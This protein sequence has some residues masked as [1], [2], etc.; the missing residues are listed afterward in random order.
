MPGCAGPVLQVRSMVINTPA[1]PCGVLPK[2]KPR[3]KIATLFC[4]R[5]PRTDSSSWHFVSYAPTSIM[6]KL[7]P[8]FPAHGSSQPPVEPVVVLSRLSPAAAVSSRFLESLDTNTAE[9]FVAVF[10]RS[11]PVVVSFPCSFSP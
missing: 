11:L 1:L 7:P 3:S 4:D 8:S 10:F 2:A 6:L 5:T 9:P